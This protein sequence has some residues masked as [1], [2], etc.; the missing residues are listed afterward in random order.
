[1]NV[2]ESVVSTPLKSLRLT[3]LL[4]L[5]HCFGFVAEVSNIIPDEARERM[6]YSDLIE[7]GKTQAG[8]GELCFRN[9]KLFLT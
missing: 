1:M 7:G 9:L 6:M 3:M 8:G 2:R 4:C 5:C